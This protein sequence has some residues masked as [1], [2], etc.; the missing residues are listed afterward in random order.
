MQNNSW[1]K[2]KESL[3]FV[4]PF[5]SSSNYNKYIIIYPYFT[6]MTRGPKR[7]LDGFFFTRVPLKLSVTKGNERRNYL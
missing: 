3:F 5:I 4:L 6:V 2:I 7:Y 1:Y